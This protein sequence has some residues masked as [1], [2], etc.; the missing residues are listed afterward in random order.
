[1]NLSSFEIKNYKVI[2][3]T[4]PVKIDPKVTAFVGKNESG[5]T[6]ILKALWKSRNVAGAKFV[7]L[8]DYPRNRYTRDREGKQQ[9]TKITFE[10]LPEDQSSFAEAVPTCL[11]APTTVAL[12]TWYEGAKV[13][14]A[15]SFNPELVFGGGD[16]ALAALEALRGAVKA[17]DEDESTI[18]LQQEIDKALEQVE[19]SEALFSSASIAALE[20]PTKALNAWWKGHNERETRTVTERQAWTDALTQAKSGDGLTRANDWAEENLPTFIY[21][22]EYGQLETEI[23]LPVFGKTLP[24]QKPELRPRCLLGVTSIPRRSSD[25]AT[26]RRSK[27]LTR[28]CIGVSRREACS[29]SLRPL[30]FPAIGPVGGRARATGWFLVRTAI[31]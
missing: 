27:N 14:H 28:M 24:T 15:V 31:T 5:K 13:C 1:M 9:I 25:W 30:N 7:K 22:D 19:T 18:A 20:M 6:G 4:G 29:W 16:T 12:S 11:T 8:D 21:F 3:D 10:L 17:T 2:D 23:H 26:P